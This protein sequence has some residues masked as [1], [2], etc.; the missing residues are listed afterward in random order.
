MCT[1]YETLHLYKVYKKYHRGAKVNTED[2]ESLEKIASMN[3][4]EFYLNR[5]D[6]LCA[7]SPYV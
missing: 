6:E 3:R 1:D 5:N 4:I 2:L 7:R